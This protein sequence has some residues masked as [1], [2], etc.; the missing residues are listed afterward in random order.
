MAQSVIKSRQE[1]DQIVDQASQYL[2]DWI[3]VELKKLSRQQHL[4]LGSTENDIYLIGSLVLLNDQ[5]RGWLVIQDIDNY[6]IFN[7]RNSAFCYC[8]YFNSNQIKEAKY[9]QELDRVIDAL[10]T[11]C[12]IYRKKIK[13]CGNNSVRHSILLS[14]YHDDLSRINIY[15]QQLRNLISIAKYTKIRNFYESNRH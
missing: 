3:N 14:R 13:S 15:K 11:N 7:S 2:V 8:L 1:F 5:T 6:E 9:I 12:D 4:I 10:L